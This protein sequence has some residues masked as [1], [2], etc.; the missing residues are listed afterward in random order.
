MINTIKNRIIYF[1]LLSFIIFSC[2]KDFNT[3]GYSLSGSDDFKFY[4]VTV[5]VF[6]SQEEAIS[7]VQ[8]NGLSI[9][10]LGS[11]SIPGIGKSSAYIIAQ[12]NLDATTKFGAY[13]A[14]QERVGNTS[15]VKVIEEKEEV[16]S[17]YLEIPFLYNQLDS[18]SDGVIDSRD[19]DP[20]DPTSDSDGDSITDALETSA[21]IDPLNEDS[22]G[23]GIL[24]PDDT[25]NSGY[26]AANK[27][28]DVDSIFGNRNAS[29]NL[30]VDELTYY[31]NELDPNNNFE[32]VQNFYS[33][34]DLYKENFV[35]ENLDDNKSTKLD[36]NEV[37]INF[38]KDDET[39]TDVDETTLVETRKTPRIRIPLKKEFFQR[40][41][42][43]I[44]G[45]DYLATTSEFKKYMRGIFIRMENLSE[46]L[47]MLLNFAQANITVDYQY[48]S[49]NDNGTPDNPNDFKYDTLKNNF[50][51]TPSLT[52][53]YLENT[54]LEQDV[55]QATKQKGEANKIFVKGGVGLLSSINL[56]GSIADG[57]AKT[58]LEELRKNSWL[59]NEANLVFYVDPSWVKGWKKGDLIAD[60]LYLYNKNDKTSLTDYLLDITTTTN[61]PNRNKSVFGGILEYKEGVPYRYKFKITRH[62]NNLIRKDSTNFPLS[63]AVSA[64]INDPSLIKAKVFENGKI[65]EVFFPTA[66]LL[67]PLSTV[68]IGSNPKEEFKNLKLELELIYTDFSKN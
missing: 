59:I 41:F 14:E 64:N 17:A 57:S 65:E 45:S 26:Q 30:K 60:R 23:D 46:D 55:L 22:D 13:T 19:I 42:I 3:V 44:E 18:D 31:L 62:V 12:L 11:I 29:F 56:F 54:M 4:R 61:S 1:F 38:E 5:P 52:V 24:D 2:N 21:G 58:K 50:V 32:T 34:R 25:D 51:L 68:L 10:Q 40:K 53:N 28:Y 6:S 7:E 33:S 9:Q 8:S 49:Y 16:I 15:D 43:D 63:L 39:T 47:Y 66:S 37:R 27:V 36:F 48:L 20:N 35:G 67:N